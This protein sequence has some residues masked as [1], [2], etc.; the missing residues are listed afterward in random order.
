M[1]MQFVK[2]ALAFQG[3]PWYFKS[4]PA[5]SRSE[6]TLKSFKAKLEF[7]KVSLGF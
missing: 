6:P 1:E 7:G 5:L 4:C 2:L 3:I